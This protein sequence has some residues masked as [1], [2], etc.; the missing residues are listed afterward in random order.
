LYL[1]GSGTVA[2]T[3]NIFLSTSNLVGIG[4]NTPSATLHVL[5]NVYVQTGN[6]GLG[7]STPAYQLDLSTDDARKLTT[8]TWLTGSDRRIKTDIVSANLAMCYETVK[9]INLK[10]FKWT[11]PTNDHHSLGFIAQEVREVFPNAVSE[12]DSFGYPDFL[13]LNTDQ[14]HKAMY[15]ALQKTMA[16]KE[17]LEARIQELESAP[18]P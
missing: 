6:V 13:S 18:P 5:G 11:I 16:D 14:I 4:T 12:S 8:S 9:A 17:E 10:Y 1:T 15:G 2:S 3:A 7:L